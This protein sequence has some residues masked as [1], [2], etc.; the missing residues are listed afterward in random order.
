MIGISQLFTHI[1]TGHYQCFAIHFKWQWCQTSGC[2][3][4]V[5]PSPS[6]H[7]PHQTGTCPQLHPASTSFPSWVLHGFVWNFWGRVPSGKLSH[8]YGK[9]LFLMGKSIISM[10]MFNSKLLNCQKVYLI[11]SHTC[12]ANLPATPNAESSADGD[13]SSKSA[14]RAQRWIVFWSWTPSQRRNPIPIGI[15][16][17]NTSIL[18]RGLT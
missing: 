17:S 8:N 18:Y 13:A 4:K 5:I 3:S 16:Q 15:Q 14:L 10:A 7:G 6:H 12:P 11:F 9:S 1:T 2:W